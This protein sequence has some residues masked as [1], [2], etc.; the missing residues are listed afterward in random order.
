MGAQVRLKQIQQARKKQ[1]EQKN[2]LKEF[3]IKQLVNYLKFGS[4][5]SDE[6]KNTVF[7]DLYTKYPNYKFNKQDSQIISTFLN[8]NSTY[9]KNNLRTLIGKRYLGNQY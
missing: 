6:E 7:Y 8:E 1:Q 4:T 5:L 9:L 2:R 3:D